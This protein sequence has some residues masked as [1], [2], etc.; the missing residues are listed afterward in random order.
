MKNLKQKLSSASCVLLGISNSAL[1]D[2]ESWIVDLGVM[3]Y[4]EQDRNTG[5][6]L[7]A[8]GT[9]E[10]DDGG[11]LNLAAELDVITGATPNGASSSNAPQTFTMSSGVGSYTVDANE[12]PV[13]DTHMDTRLGLKAAWTDPLSNDLTVD[14]NALISM[15]FDY[16]AFAAGG[17]LAWDFNR[18]NTTLIT[19]INLEYNRVH[20]VGNTPTPF[21]VMQPPGQQQPRGVSA[22]SKIGEEFSIG[23]NQVIDRHSL[24]QIRLT[25]SHFS[26]YLTDP[27]K[28]LSIV[29]NETPVT[30]GATL[31]ATQSYVFEHR[32]DSRTMKSLYLAYK[33]AYQPGVLDVSYRL[34]DD[35]WDIRSHTVDVA[36]KFNLQDRYFVRPNLRLYH[37]DQ[38]FFYRH[39]LK[40]D[41]TLPNFASADFRLAD[42]DAT[43]LGLEFGRDLAFDRKHSITIEYY[44]QQGDSHP[45][46]AVGLQ[47]QQDLYPELRT[48][49]LKYV[50]SLKW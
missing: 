21:G 19:G 22:K 17:N 23:L 26:G 11:A 20:P 10:L 31:G 13:D 45:Q 39:S 28:L 50:Y 9:R 8:R 27:Y 32:P 15:E 35:S 12:L 47:R 48:L 37:Q 1:S 46:D 2:S 42:F 29:D 4:I 44:N 7:I 25:T 30:L 16:L 43:T 41:E 18:N 24:A 33:H 36:F 38:A 34:Y 40:S 5:L 49:V 14:Y 6:E 3:N